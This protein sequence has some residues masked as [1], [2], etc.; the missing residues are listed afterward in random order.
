MFGLSL[1]FDGCI[2]LGLLV[3]INEV[4]LFKKNK[5]LINKI[6]IKAIILLHYSGWRRK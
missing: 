4:C 1:G 2:A 6:E 3:F 5:C